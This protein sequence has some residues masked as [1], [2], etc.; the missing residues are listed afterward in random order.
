MT[1][2]SSF[3]V[4]LSKIKELFSGSCT[5]QVSNPCLFSGIL[6]RTCFPWKNYSVIPHGTKSHHHLQDTQKYTESSLSLSPWSSNFRIWALMCL[7]LLF[8]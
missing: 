4:H 1:L 8:R 6:S 2:D 3:L 7:S 5:Q